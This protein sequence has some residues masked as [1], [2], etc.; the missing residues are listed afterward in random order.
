MYTDKKSVLQLVSLVRAYGI[1]RVVLCP[2]SRNAPLVQ[3]FSA[4]DAFRCYS[5]TDERSAG[6]FALGLAL[7]SQAPVAA[8]PVRPCS[9]CNPP[10]ARLSTAKFL[11]WWCRPTARRRG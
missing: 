4:C 6:F 1:S 3:A 10:C 9:T 11:W 5:I 2:G 7:R 8:R